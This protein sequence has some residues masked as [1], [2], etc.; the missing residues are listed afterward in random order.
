MR[1][2]HDLWNDHTFRTLL[3][4][5]FKARRDDALGP[6]RLSMLLQYAGQNVTSPPR[7]VRTD[8]GV[9][10]VPHIPSPTPPP[11][12]IGDVATDLP[13]GFIPLEADGPASTEEIKTFKQYADQ[14]IKGRPA[15]DAKLRE[16]AAKVA[17]HLETGAWDANGQMTIRLPRYTQTAG[18]EAIL[19]REFK[20]RFSHVDMSL[21]PKNTTINGNSPSASA[22]NGSQGE[23]VDG[24]VLLFHR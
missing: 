24:W 13:P 6:V 8:Y 9:Q 12:S 11:M 4:D 14:Q 17:Q 15:P 16:V 2:P 23:S 1:D 5:L 20:S 7:A 10:T 3:D 22:V 21:P 18:L 19:K